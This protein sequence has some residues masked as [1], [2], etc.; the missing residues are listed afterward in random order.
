MEP[1]TCACGHESTAHRFDY[2]LLE[3]TGCQLCDDCPSVERFF[4][5]QAR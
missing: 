1:A 3:F 2:E 5:A 4:E